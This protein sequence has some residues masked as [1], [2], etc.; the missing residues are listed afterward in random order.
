MKNVTLSID[1]RL[2]EE[3]RCYA[4]AHKTSLN[5]LI[6]KVLAQTVCEQ[7]DDSTSECFRRM[8]AA[9]GRSGGKRWKR[10]GLY[11]V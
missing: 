4:K 5:A 6:R 2:L 7:H 1:D 10:E 9:Q 8:D 3:G 11:D